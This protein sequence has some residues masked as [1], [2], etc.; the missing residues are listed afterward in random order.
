VPSLTINDVSVVEGNSGTTNVAFTVSLS[1]AS[2][3]T[4]SVNYATTNGTALAGSD[5]MAT[6]GT[7]SFLPGQTNQFITVLVH[8]DTNTE[9]GE[10]YFVNLSGAVN[11]SIGNAQGAGLI[12]NDDGCSLQ[13]NYVATQT[14]LDGLGTTTMPIT[15]DG[16]NYWSVSGGS[17]SGNRL[18]RYGTSGN[19]LA[20]YAPGL[21]FRSVFTDAAGIVYARAY[22]SP[23]IYRQTAPGVLVTLVVM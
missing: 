16:A 12:V 13:T 20:T 10:V 7:V 2:A 1:V 11:A 3:L 6:N 23:T 22:G 14:F 9:P 15:F 19:L 4:V 8:G 18:A 21:D 5:Y 17:S